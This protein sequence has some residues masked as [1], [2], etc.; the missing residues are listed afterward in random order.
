[1]CQGDLK[2]Q[3]LFQWLVLFAFPLSVRTCSSSRGAILDG[4]GM[5]YL[6]GVLPLQCLVWFWNFYYSFLFWNTLHTLGC[7]FFDYGASPAGKTG[8]TGQG[9]GKVLR[10]FYKCCGKKNEGVI[11]RVWQFIKCSSLSPERETL[12][13]MCLSSLEWNH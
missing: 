4:E 5:T 9:Q 11:C 2:Y 12:A 13:L 10:S 7:C 6:L 3:D 1:M 8:G